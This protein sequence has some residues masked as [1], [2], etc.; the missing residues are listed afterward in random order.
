MA[1][2]I[3]T[4]DPGVVFT[5]EFCKTQE[6]KSLLRFITCGSVDDG[7]STLIGRMLFDT[8][9]ISDN[10][11]SNLEIDSK[12]IGTQRG[13]LDF[14]LMLDGL[15]AER[16]Q[17]ITIDVAYRQFATDKRR[18]IVADTPGHEQYTRNMATG[19]STADLAII[20][21]DARKGVQ[22]QTRRH[23]YIV[24][25]LA[26]HNIIV[27]INKMDLVNFSQ[28]IFNGIVEEYKGFAREI[29]LQ[30]ISFIPVSALNGDNV[31]RKSK[32]A[33]WYKSSTL[34]EK[35]ETAS[36][37]NEISGVAFRFPVQW[38]NRPNQDFRGFSGTVVCGEILKGDNV[39]ALPSGARSKIKNIVSF[40]R[41]LDNA[42][43]GQAVTLQLEDE[44][45]VVRGDVLVAENDQPKVTDQFMA[46]LLWMDNEPMLQNRPY[47][48]KVNTKGVSATITDLKYKI[49]VNTLA[50]NS[51]KVLYLN[52]LGV[53]NF[54][55]GEPIVFEPYIENKPMGSFV[56]IDEKTDNTV[57]MG[58]IDYGLRRATNL[59]LQPFDI[60]KYERGL[61]KNQ[62][63]VV[64]WFTGLSGSGKST[65]SNIVEQR[66]YAR[67][68]HTVL[69]DG[70]NV[71]HGLNRDLGF[72]DHDRIENIRRISETSKLM[73]DAGLM[74][75]VSCISPFESDR[76]MA[77]NLLAKDEFIE[78]FIDASFNLCAS[79]DPKGLY[80][81]AN[82]GE[83]KNFSG[84][85]SP[86][87]EPKHSEIVIDSANTEAVK[88]AEQIISYLEQHGYL[89]RFI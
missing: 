27:A 2:S 73:L 32:H 61:L 70:D 34:I 6:Q 46:H 87:E 31:F 14:A 19:A 49:D 57:A 52:E 30:N 88:A 68:K 18:F 45:S 56:L 3:V 82:N 81:K 83:I 39:V 16:E 1:K 24:S 50:H 15:S 80:K 17:G 74:V 13:E 48:L 20:L 23:S 25:Q 64:I 26:V 37:I 55:L 72:T 69:L 62:K 4:A 86:Y 22:I 84:L 47:I 9:H 67:G 51:A 54:L 65:I 5:K 71:R 77:R 60:N 41:R 53:C 38:I 59:Q 7:K 12:K 10:Q 75:L 89:D 63:P 78:I 44:I 40:D 66:L 21:V 35:L 79:R 42:I 85:D 58:T 76:H 43:V 8:K 36:I 28:E 11:L 33:D 29:N